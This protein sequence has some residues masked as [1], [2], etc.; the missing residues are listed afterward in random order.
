MLSRRVKIVATVGPAVSEAEEL[1][2]L[3]GAGMNVA[4]LNFSHGTHEAHGRMAELIRQQA[5]EQGRIVALLADLCG[6]KIRTGEGG[7]AQVDSGSE[8]VLVGRGPL[9]ADELPVDFGTIHQDVQ[10]EDRI[11]LGDGHVELKVEAIEGYRVRCRVEHGGKLRSKMGVN[12]PAARIQAPSITEKDQRDLAYALKMGVDYVAL[13]FVR[14]A[15]DIRKLRGY[16]EEF[17]RPVPVVAKVETPQAVDHLDAIVEASDAVMVA[18]GDLGV[19]LPA[20]RVPVVQREIVGCCRLHRTPV[21]V[22][23]EMLQSMVLAP[24][25]T[26]AEASD[27]ASAVYTGADAVMLSGETATGA[28]PIRACQMMSRIIAEAEASR[29]Y[30]PEASPVEG[31]AEA[32]AHSACQIAKTVDARCVVAVTES[33]G[34]ARLVSKARPGV[35]IIALSPDARNLRQLALLWG[36][37]PVSMDV[38][39]DVDTLLTRINSLLKSRRLTTAG[40]RFVVVYGAPVHNRAPT[41]SVRVEV[42]R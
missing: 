13:S 36:V 7:P 17:G 21:I 3:I 25:P 40:D 30:A 32:L 16:C 12:L 35:P 18:R 23:T 27:V 31:T 42:A 22:A 9:A 8:L 2:E 24:R 34:T 6:P 29:F 38:M 4:R 20:E 33:G 5:A 10:V 1:A 15:D 11:L 28:F 14:S 39:P 41:N 19:E 26:R 37:E